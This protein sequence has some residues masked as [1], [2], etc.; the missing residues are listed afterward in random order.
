MIELRRTPLFAEHKALG[1]KLVPFAGWEMPLQYAPGIVAEHSAV[2][3][4]A[5]LFDV[6]HMAR[7]EV[8]GDGAV[9]FV[10][11]LITNNLSKL[12]AGRLLYTPMCRE[13]GGVLDD[14]TVYRFDDRVW[15]VV[16]AGNSSRIW[17]WIT[18]RRAHWSGAQCE[19]RDRSEALGQIAF[20][21]PRAQEMLSPHAAGD[22]DAVPYYGFLRTRLF[23][24]DDVVV[25]RN[26]YTGEDGFELYAPAERLSELWRAILGAGVRFGV[27]PAG[28]GCRDTLRL[29]MAYCLYGNELDLDVSPLEA[30]LQ[31]TVKLAKPDFVGKQAL[32]RQKRDGL[33]RTLAPFVVEGQRLVRKGQ[34]VRRA[35]AASI[36][37]AGMAIGR[38]TS[39]GYSPSLERGIGLAFVPPTESAPGTRL[40]ADVRGEPV[41]IEIVEAPFYKQAS[42]R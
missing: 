40:S 5:G 16:N 38:V 35:S 29:E 9:E 2:R 18:E 8:T 11:S 14:V 15:V 34:T 10:D 39:A 42:H 12:A 26:G 25:S 23:E 30:R 24:I 28:L 6:S 21:G 17:D 22:L 3:R 41:A 27:I 33:T 20:Q 7:F 19:V 31:W 37:D 36:A 32:E 1:G 13:D 4:A